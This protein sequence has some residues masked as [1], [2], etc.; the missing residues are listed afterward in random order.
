MPQTFEGFNDLYTKS[1][2]VEI[3]LN[4]HKKSAKESKDKTDRL[5]VATITLSDKVPYSVGSTL[6]KKP[7]TMKLGVAKKPPPL[8]TTIAA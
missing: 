5:L 8:A 7:Y 1:H 2:D 3:H 4:K 6:S